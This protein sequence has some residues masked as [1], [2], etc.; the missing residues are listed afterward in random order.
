MVTGEKDRR[1]VLEVVGVRGVVLGDVGVKVVETVDVR[2][3]IKIVGMDGV[4]SCW[5]CRSGWCSC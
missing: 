5:Y 2:E 3:G 1:I 4:C